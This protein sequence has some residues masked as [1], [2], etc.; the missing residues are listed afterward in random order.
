MFPYHALDKVAD[1]D[2]SNVLSSPCEVL[3]GIVGNITESHHSQLTTTA[4]FRFEYK[5]VI[6]ISYT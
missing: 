2:R 3:N 4:T 6:H 1:R 5:L